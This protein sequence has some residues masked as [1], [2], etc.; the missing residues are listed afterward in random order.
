MVVVRDLLRQV[1][2]PRATQLFPTSV[3][4]PRASTRRGHLDVKGIDVDER[5]VVKEHVGVRDWNRTVTRYFTSMELASLAVR[6]EECLILMGVQGEDVKPRAAS[7][8]IRTLS[9]I[10]AVKEHARVKDRE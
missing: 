4:A 2:G 3:R 10:S 9:T 5:R 8:S 7:P 6:D 1:L